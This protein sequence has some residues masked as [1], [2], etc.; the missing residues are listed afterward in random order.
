M[1][2]MTSMMMSMMIVIRLFQIIAL[3][4]SMSIM[5]WSTSSQGQRT[6]NP[7][8]DTDQLHE[9]DIDLKK[10]KTLNYAKTLSTISNSTF[11]I[12]EALVLPFLL[13]TVYQTRNS[14]S[15][16]NVYSNY[17]NN[18]FRAN[19]LSLFKA[20]QIQQRSKATAQCTSTYWSAFLCGSSQY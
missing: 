7:T 11:T 8:C 15:G 5:F 9:K 6:S 20:T 2:M 16:P 1:V 12:S 17:R 19:P 4:R 13:F 10:K 3:C 18:V 14:S